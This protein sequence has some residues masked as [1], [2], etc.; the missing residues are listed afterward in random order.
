MKSETFFAKGCFF[1][2]AGTF[3]HDGSW[4][5][6]QLPAEPCPQRRGRGRQRDAE[7]CSQR[8]TV[9]V[10]HHISPC[11]WRW[12]Q[13]IPHP[14]GRPHQAIIARPS[15]PGRHCQAVFATKLRRMFTGGRQCQTPD[16]SHGTR[17]HGIRRHGTPPE[18]SLSF[19]V[20]ALHQGR[21][22]ACSRTLQVFPQKAIPA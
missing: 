6:F 19:A 14:R 13:S 4:T 15:S 21:L 5:S 16:S 11:P 20:P 2:N 3:F 1:S 8:S 22:T 9:H 7:G 10:P 17:R 12:N 18:G